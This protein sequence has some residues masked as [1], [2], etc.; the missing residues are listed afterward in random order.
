MGPDH[1]AH[2]GLAR[3]FQRLELFWSLSVCD[4]VRVGSESNVQWWR[5]SHIRSLVGRNGGSS[6][7][8]GQRAIGDKAIRSLLRRVGLDGLADHPVDSL[9]TGQARLVELARALAIGPRVL[10]LDE[11]G[12]GLD[13]SESTMLGTLLKQLAGE[14]MAILLVEHDMGL[15]MR[16]C[17][18]VFVLDF[19]EL[20]AS[21]TPDQVR[22]DPAVQI[23]YLGAPPTDAKDVDV[24]GGPVR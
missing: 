10:L 22:A 13:E 8:A 24:A 21:G 18:R 2:L 6:R 5:I 3:T 20:I 7:V 15:L 11:P 4:N 12:S 14:G 19:G 1:R 9:P 16:V 23:A 17:E